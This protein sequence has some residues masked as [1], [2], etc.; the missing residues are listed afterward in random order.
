MYLL[1]VSWITFIASVLFIFLVS[2]IIKGVTQW[3]KWVPVWLVKEKV[4]WN[5]IFSYNLEEIGN[6]EKNKKIKQ[7][8]KMLCFD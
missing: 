5:L 6:N 7:A 4:L 2:D 3:A 1:A 8:K